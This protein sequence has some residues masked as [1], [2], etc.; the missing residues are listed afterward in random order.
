M[1][2]NYLNFPALSRGVYL[3]TAAAGLLSEQ[4]GIWRK[5]HESDTL[6]EGNLLAGKADYFKDIKVLVSSLFDAE[7]QCTYLAPN[8]SFGFNTFLDGLKPN[9]QFLLLEEDYPSIHYAVTSRGFEHHCVGIDEF[10][11]ERILD[12]VRT[13]KPTVFAFSLVQY[14]SGI[15]LSPAF[16]RLLK[17]QFPDLL[18]VADGTQFCG[19]EAFSF[20]T[21]GLDLL[22]SSGYKWM[23]AGYGNAFLFTNAQL[24]TRIYQKQKTRPLPREPF[25]KDKRFPAH[26]FEPGHQD[27]LSMG[28]L[29]EAARQLAE[30]GL[31]NIAAAIGN[32]KH[33]A[34]TAFSDRNLLSPAVLK[35]EEHSGIFN[36]ALAEEQI[37]RINRAGIRCTPRGSGLRVGFHFY[38]TQDDLQALLDVIDTE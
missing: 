33:A 23:L 20:R 24:H 38:N 27:S 9:E 5:R 26:Y 7:E 2:K 6:T 10:L 3:N 28:T 12:A 25:L 31:D 29:G 35:R 11:E 30:T 13:H 18:L 36:L 21:S 8:F 16:L 15:R 34:K 19:T 37:S 4:T 22:G 17:E 1:Q 14:I 32:L